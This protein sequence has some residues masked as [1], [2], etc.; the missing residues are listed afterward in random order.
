MSWWVPLAFIG[1]GIV[2]LAIALSLASGRQRSSS[3][4]PQAV[5]QHGGRPRS[6]YEE[7]NELRWNP[8]AFVAALALIGLLVLI[9]VV[10]EAA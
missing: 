1:A 2:G 4:P 9:A 5:Q 7:D 3:P 6:R 8:A 10:V